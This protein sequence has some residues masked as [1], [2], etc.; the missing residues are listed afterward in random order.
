MI[1]KNTNNQMIK[2]ITDTKIEGDLVFDGKVI[3]E[4][5]IEITGK[6]DVEEV[7]AKKSI[8]VHLAYIVKKTDKV[9]ESQDVGWS[10]DVGESQEVGGYQKVGGY[11]DVG[12]YQKVGW[13]QK[14]GGSQKVGEYQEVGEYR[15][16]SMILID[17]TKIKTSRITFTATYYHERNFWITQL[18]PIA[19]TEKLQEAI[20]K[21]CWDNIIEVAKSI[22]DIL[23]AYPHWIPAVRQAVELLVNK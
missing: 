7:E 16:Q 12:E 5:D 4:N 22:K 14:V 21:E 20:K 15:N 23:L 2:I 18:S 19:G 8:H 13:S 6:L 1:A 11:Q 3:F 10:Q 9:G 17:L